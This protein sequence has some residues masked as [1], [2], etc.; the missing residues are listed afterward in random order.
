MRRET[1]RDRTSRKT[2]INVKYRRSEDAR[3]RFKKN[4]FFCVCVC[5]C[6]RGGGETE[7]D[8]GIETET[9]REKKKK[10][11]GNGEI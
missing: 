11:R 7:G 9:E 4:G 8:K 5:V 1:K 6:G 10:E 2:K 3:N